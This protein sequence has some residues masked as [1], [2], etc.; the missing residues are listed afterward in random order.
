[1]EKEVFRCKSCLNLS[2]RPRIEFNDKQVCNACL[3]AEEKK[4]KVDWQLRQTEL[5]H[6][7]E[8]IGD[9][10]NSIVLYRSVGEKT[11]VT[12]HTW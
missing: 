8:N 6:L 12:S 11:A 5:E 3:W 4:H 2:T 1:M 7:L 9:A 10:R